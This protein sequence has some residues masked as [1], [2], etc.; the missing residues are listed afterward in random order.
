METKMGFGGGEGANDKS[1][2]GKKWSGTNSGKDFY[3]RFPLLR[4][5]EN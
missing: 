5:W 3:A 2:R 4:Q 1:G